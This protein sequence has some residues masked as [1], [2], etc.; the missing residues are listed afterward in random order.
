[1]K[2]VITASI[3][4]DSEILELLDE[5]VKAI[6]DKCGRTNEDLY[7]DDVKWG[8]DRFEVPVFNYL[9]D[10]NSEEIAVF[11]FIYDKD[12]DLSIEEQMH[13]Q[14]DEFLQELDQEDNE[15]YTGSDFVDDA[16]D[17]VVSECLEKYRETKPHAYI[18][19]LVKT[20]LTRPPYN[21]TEDEDFTSNDILEVID[22]Y[23]YYWS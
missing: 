6:E 16:I 2:K 10:G 19:E 14:L 11:R 13:I 12:E 3:S 7:P 8:K 20:K 1:M 4:D 18:V 23:K 5:A 21:L 9:G 22:N 15:E 17:D